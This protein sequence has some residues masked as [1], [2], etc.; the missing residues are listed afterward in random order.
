MA[1]ATAVGLHSFQ[2]KTIVF[3]ALLIFRIINS[4]LVQTFFQPDEYFQALEPAWQIAFG[5]DSGAWITW[6]WR[7]GLR[8][9]VH[10]YLFAAAY[11]AVAQICELVQANEQF[12]AAALLAAPRLLQAFWAAG[13]DLSTWR[14]ACKLY[15]SGH[16]ASFAALALTVLSPWQWFCSVRTFSNSIETTLTIFSLTYFPWGRFLQ[17][18]N[19]RQA[20]QQ[21]LA[22]DGAS[23]SA[24]LYTALAAA[25]AA[26]YLRPTNI[27]IWLSISAGLVWYSRSIAK[28]AVLI[29]AAVICG[30]AVIV[31]FAGADR[32]Y[33]ETWTFPPLRFLQF[34]VVQSL[35]VFYGKNRPDY[36]FTEGLPL[37]LTTALPFAAT[38]LYY[39][40]RGA[41]ISRTSQNIARKRTASILAVTV[42]AT[43]AALS[44]ISHKEMRFIYPLLPILHVLAARP[45]ASIFATR[46]T[47]RLSL[48]VI[49]VGM[50][51]FIAFYVSFVHQRG[52]VDVMHY[53][54]HR[55][56]AWNESSG[57]GAANVS[58]G[59][60]M[61]CHSTPWRSH[62][63]Y[64]GIQAWA[65]TCEPPIHVPL[66][67]RESYLDEADVFYANPA[68]WLD[69]NMQDRSSIS[70]TTELDMATPDVLNNAKRPWPHYL[71]A[72]EQLQPTMLQVLEGSRYRECKRFFNTHW[73]DDGRRRGD[74]IVWCMRR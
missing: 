1:T 3:I 30:S 24:S 13:M 74:V 50:N 29:Q 19:D 53:L 42:I 21:R 9:S 11:K 26:F 39:S 45:L 56:E 58:V 49:G 54:R 32:T 64:P 31:A 60:L 28:A 33:Y 41:K 12:R 69:E 35:A 44:V 67:A 15:G 48:L 63:V 65:L 52:V 25:A 7:E 5:P 46:S 22:Q 51:A 73:L 57:A 47:A 8:T 20:G 4:Q 40:L 55:Q 38:G 70:V 37:L 17:P 27:I 36:Y 66:D 62:L 59:F 34:N 68:K 43:V 10:P 6:E 2:A 16:A 23:S 61:P 18:S 72:F 14:M 71:V